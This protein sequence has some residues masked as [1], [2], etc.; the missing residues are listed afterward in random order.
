MLEYLFLFINLLSFKIILITSSSISTTTL[1]EFWLS[2]PLLIPSSFSLSA[3]LV[4]HTSSNHLSL[5]LTSGRLPIGFHSN[6]FFPVLEVS[7]FCTWPNHLIPWALIIFPA[8]SIDRT[9]QVAMLISIFI[10]L[11][12]SKGCLSDIHLDILVWDFVAISFSRVRLLALCPT[13]TWRVSP[14]NLYPPGAR[15]PSYTP[16]HWVAQV[17]RECHFMY[18]QMWAPEGNLNH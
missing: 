14:Q 10:I 13:P 6:F 9:F 12:R 4:W 16:R 18:P 2:Y 15:L 5:G 8:W 1:C 17:P 3:P 7:L 11:G